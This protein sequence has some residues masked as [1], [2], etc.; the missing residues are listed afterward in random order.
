MY[1]KEFINKIMNIIENV[2]ECEVLSS[3][4]TNKIQTKNNNFA[5]KL[6]DRQLIDDITRKNLLVYV[7]VYMDLCKN[8]QK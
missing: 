3:N 2:E 6:R 1:K 8:S 4:A 5:N 7:L